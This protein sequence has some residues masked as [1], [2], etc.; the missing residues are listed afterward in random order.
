MF[1]EA[2]ESGPNATIRIYRDKSDLADFECLLEEGAKSLYL[3]ADE[4]SAI[5]VDV[6]KGRNQASLQVVKKRKEMKRNGVGG[7]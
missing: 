3:S 1:G 2:K 7:G 4:G 5:F 6:R